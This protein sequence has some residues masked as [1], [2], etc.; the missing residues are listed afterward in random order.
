M[1]DRPRRS[2]ITV[3]GPTSHAVVE[4]Q[5]TLMVLLHAVATAILERT[6]DIFIRDTAYFYCDSLNYESQFIE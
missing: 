2:H 5:S 6:V 1:S 3:T 4:L